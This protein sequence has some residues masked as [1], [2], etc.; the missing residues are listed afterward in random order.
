MVRP[1]TYKTMQCLLVIELLV[2]QRGVDRK[3]DGTTS[4]NSS[5]P[6]MRSWAVRRLPKLLRFSPAKRAIER[7]PKSD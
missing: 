5:S 1:S 2:G 4:R 3:T 7:A 6:N